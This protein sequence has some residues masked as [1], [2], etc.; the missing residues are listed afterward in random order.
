MSADQIFAILVYFALPA[1]VAYPLI[2][3]FTSPWW[4]SWIGRALL[5]KALGVAT[6]IIFSTL[7]Q[8][9]GP[10]YPGRNY[11]RIIGMFIADIGFWFALFA[12][13]QVKREVWKENHDGRPQGPGRFEKG[14]ENTYREDR[15]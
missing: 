3:G 6:L 5:I 10:D 4:R 15:L 1:T 9:F 11:I 7:F 12:L 14:V 2:Y 13:I 8:L